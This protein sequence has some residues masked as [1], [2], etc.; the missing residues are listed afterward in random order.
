MDKRR[1]GFIAGMIISAG[2]LFLAFRGLQPEQFW[3]S[4]SD[5]DLAILA[6]ATLTYILAVII[7]ALRWQYLL[8][9]I[10]LVPL[11]ALSQLVFIGYMGNNVYPLRAGDA[12]RIYL[13]RR[14]HEVPLV[15]STTVVV[16][17]RL[18][19]GSVMLSFIFLSLL[20]IDIQSDAVAA[21][22]TV[23]AP[24][25]VFALLVAFFLAAKPQLLRALIR[26]VAQL[27][28]QSV[29]S[30][31]RRISEDIIVGLEGLRSPFY[32]LGA[33]ASSFITWGIEAGTYWLVMRAFGLELNYAVALLLVGAVNLAGLIP[34]SPGQVGVNEFVIITILSALG[35]PVAAATAYAVVTHLVIWLAPTSIG[36]ILLLRQG[37]GWADI[38]R[39][40]DRE[41][42]TLPP[43][44]A[45]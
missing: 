10:K 3:D 27:P 19:D 16:L 34:A 1:L 41:A 24:L 25:F 12:L 22:T 23:T 36:F 30:L 21:I 28:P 32:L 44:E 39:A 35:Q 42:D 37:M 9:A 33:V 26:L 20:F 6:A 8:R 43:I 5:I 15:R 4:L 17:E 29:G 14:N 38:R 11:S 40:G 2:F 13:L 31:V 18:F 7:I 45:T